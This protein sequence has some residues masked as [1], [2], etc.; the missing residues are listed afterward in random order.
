M[1]GNSCPMRGEKILDMYFMENRARLLEI[2]SF[3]DRID[4]SADP[5]SAIYDF[6]YSSFMQAI[7]SLFKE[8]N[9]VKSAQLIFSDMSDEPIESAVGL[10]TYGAWEER[11]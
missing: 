2:A 11:G 3:L 4:R 6:R 5:A 8:N 9:R 7:E 10:K 1:G